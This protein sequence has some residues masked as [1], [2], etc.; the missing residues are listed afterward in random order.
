[1][2]LSAAVRAGLAAA[3]VAAAAL[4]VPAGAASTTTVRTAVIDA[5]Q[6]IQCDLA[7]APAPAAAPPVGT[8]PCTGVRPGA[9]IQTPHGPCSMGFLF[10]GNDGRRY[11]STAGHCVLGVD[12]EM[13]WRN[14][15]GAVA[16]DAAGERIGTAVYAIRLPLESNK[17]TDFA[18]I[19]LDP[20][21]ASDPQM[22][23]FGGPT[24]LASEVNNDT[25]VFEHVGTGVAGLR[26]RTAVAPQG[27]YRADY[28]YAHGAGYPGDSGGALIRDDGA[29]IG[30]VTQLTYGALGNVGINR[31]GPH[32]IRAGN[33]IRV[34]LTLL[35]AP[36]L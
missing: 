18:L 27:L 12:G 4:A 26:S 35:T 21:V 8:A 14:G 13:I 36:L 16:K 19:R 10:A 29:A 31:I 33:A 32:V 25:A 24:S 28:V 2:S 7:D 5:G 11:I 3:L 23:H 15:S 30:L 34:N 6:R 9:Q 17:M 20:G 22:C 1:V